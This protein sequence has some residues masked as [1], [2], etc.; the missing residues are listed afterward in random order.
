MKRARALF[1]RV[2]DVVVRPNS[3]GLV[4]QFMESLETRQMLSAPYVTAAA[5]NYETLPH[6]VS[7]TFDQDV[8]ASLSADDL[9]L[10]RVGDDS[11]ISSSD[12]SESYDTTTDTATF[13][14]TPG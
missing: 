12:L 13:S 5:F 1:H 3:S 6:K 10:Q 11:G 7:F 9:L 2:C 8:S 14:Y 4:R